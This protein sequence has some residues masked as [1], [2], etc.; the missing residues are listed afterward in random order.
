[1]DKMDLMVEMDEID[2]MFK[3]AEKCINMSLPFTSWI[4]SIEK[5]R[6]IPFNMVGMDIIHVGV[7]WFRYF[8]LS[9][10]TMK[11]GEWWAV[12][13]DVRLD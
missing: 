1:M 2:E 3:D 9:C 13:G 7:H 8:T 6:N 4:S 11:S 5:W 12:S 10:M